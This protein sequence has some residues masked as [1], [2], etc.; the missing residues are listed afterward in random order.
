MNNTKK[1]TITLER[2]S[3]SAK[4]DDIEADWDSTPFFIKKG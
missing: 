1:T 4:S 2:A 3:S